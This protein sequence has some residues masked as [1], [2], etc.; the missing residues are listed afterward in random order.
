MDT[1]P[2]LFRP[3]K[4]DDGDAFGGLPSIGGAP[5]SILDPPSSIVPWHAGDLVTFNGLGFESRVIELGTR[6]PSHVA[7][8]LIIAGRPMLYESTTLCPLA[9]ELCRM[10]VNGVQ[11]HMPERRIAGYPGAVYR[12]PL[13]IPLRD[14]E[15]ERLTEYALREFPPGTPYDL[16]G[17]VESGPRW[18]HWHWLLPYPD[19]GSI[20]CSALCARLLMVANRMNWD[21]A[22]LYSPADLVRV[23]R[24]HDVHGAPE[25]VALPEVTRAA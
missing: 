21:D 7:I 15:S 19:L 3:E 14:E 5:S 12:L 18:K 6:G 11:A 1:F 2:R 8:V 22:K 16:K 23:Q 13:K 25:R 10:K 20:F 4:Y 9:C 17:A 24:R